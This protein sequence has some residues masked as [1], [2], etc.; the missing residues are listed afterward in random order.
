MMGHGRQNIKLDKG[1]HI[2]MDGGILPGCWH[3]FFKFEENE[4]PH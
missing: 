3:G 1:E 2:D 4:D